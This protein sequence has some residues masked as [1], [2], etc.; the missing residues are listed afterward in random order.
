MEALSYKSFQ[1]NYGKSMGFLRA[2]GMFVSFLRR[3]AESAGGKV[4]ELP[5]LEL[6][7]SQ[8]CQCGHL[9]KKSLSERWHTCP[10]CGIVAQRD[11]Y[12]AYLAY[13]VENDVLDTAMALSSWPSAEPLLDQVVSRLRQQSANEGIAFPQSFEVRILSLS[14]SGSPEKKSYTKTNIR[15]VASGT[16]S[17]NVP[18]KG[19]EQTFRTPGL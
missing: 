3:K 10:K 12:S 7:L 8:T 9:E 1:R 16:C 5:A 14:Q 19:L 13:H 4:M 6:K 2:P 11:L 17:R 18:E 15:F